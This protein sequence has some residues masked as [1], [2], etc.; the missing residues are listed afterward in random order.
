MANKEL[1]T[2]SIKGK[3]YVEVKERILYLANEIK[4]YSIVTDYTYFQDRKMW[5][6]RAVLTI[7]D[8]TYTGL[9]QEVESDSYKD[10]NHASA[11]ENCETSAVGRA[12]AM[13]GIGVID[14]IASVDEITKAKNRG[15]QFNSSPQAHPEPVVNEN[16]VQNILCSYYDFDTKQKKSCGE[17]ATLVRKDKEHKGNKYDVYTCKCGNDTWVKK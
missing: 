1:K 13:A 17:M 6:V 16:G 9:A 7:K 5:V 10:V 8:K 12:C 14:S 4:D 3:K 2:I 15:S 11:L